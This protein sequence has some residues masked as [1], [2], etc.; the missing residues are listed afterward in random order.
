M[1]RL[2]AILRAKSWWAAAALQGIVIALCGTT[3]LFD[4]LAY[5]Y[6]ATLAAG[7]ALTLAPF[8]LAPLPRSDERNLTPR[9]AAEHLGAGTAL[10]LAIAWGAG[11]ALQIWERNCDVP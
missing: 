1:A 4:L 8:L 7:A 6:A 5:E 2:R 9:Q 11:Y 10:L 3:P